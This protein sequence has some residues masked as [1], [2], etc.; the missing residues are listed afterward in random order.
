MDN[1]VALSNWYKDD[2]DNTFCI[3]YPLTENSVVLDVGGYQGN[4]SA[5]I[6]QKYNP[7]IYVFEPVKN[8]Y[9][10][11][12]ARLKHNPKIQVF[13]FG[14]GSHDEEVRISLDGDGSRTWGLGSCIELVSMRDVAKLVVG[15]IDLI[16][17]NIEGGEYDLL[18]R[19]I[20]TGVAMECR[21]IQIQFHN[22]YPDCDKLR[23]DIREQLS[24]THTE[25]YNY[26]FVWEGWKR[27]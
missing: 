4:W 12:R 15:L 14:L 16:S 1:F 26:P 17:I 7:F 20:E 27:K 8:S 21:N 11:A 6:A 18:P 22:N 9:E 2:G 19:M 24:K 13:N 3:D 5:K 10:V 25:I 23:N